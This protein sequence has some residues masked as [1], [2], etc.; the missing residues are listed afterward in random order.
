MNAMNASPRNAKAEGLFPVLAVKS[1]LVYES[2]III[3]AH[4]GQ[5]MVCMTL[6]TGQN[7]R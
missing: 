1:S 5:I 3:L 7:P 2:R 6:E 4:F